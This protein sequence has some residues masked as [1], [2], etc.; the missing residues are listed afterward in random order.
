VTGQAAPGT[1][2]FMRHVSAD[3][4]SATLRA[5]VVIINTSIAGPT[6]SPAITIPVYLPSQHT[7]WC[8]RI[9]ARTKGSRIACPK[10]LIT[11]TRFYLP[12]E[13]EWPTWDVDDDNVHLGPLLEVEDSWLRAS[14]GR[15]MDDPEQAVYIIG[16]L[17]SASDT[18]SLFR[19]YHLS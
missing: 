7:R 16:E 9:M 19:R 6:T 5:G 12:R 10:P 14:L 17:L 8:P 2:F 18:D 3:F 13:Q 4:N 1:P 11:W 15:M